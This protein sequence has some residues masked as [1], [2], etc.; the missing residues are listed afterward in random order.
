[1]FNRAS[2]EVIYNDIK[3]VEILEEKQKHRKENVF[4]NINF[5]TD[6]I[7]SDVT[8]R[9]PNTEQD[10]LANVNLTI[11]KNKSAAFIGPSGAGKTTLADI[12]LGVLEPS[13]GDV[14]VDGVSVLDKMAAWHAKLG[15]IPQSIYLLDDTIKRNIAFAIPDEEIDEKRLRRA[16]EEAQLTEFI[17]SLEDGVETEI[18]E[19]GVRLSGGQRQRIGIARALY[20]NPEV[21]ILDEA[22]SAL[23]TETEKAVMDAIDSLNGKKTLII[24]AHRLSTI[25]N[26]DLIFEI[27]DTKVVLKD[28][29]TV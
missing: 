18:G 11:P 2:V 6:I 8:F 4:A 29:N 13:N 25:K 3:E 21:L 16:I 5:N 28:K 27:K 9:Y 7:I 10:V 1:M 22:T 12:I 24:I 15:Y 26:C 17:D 20:T 23:D 14:L 19:Q